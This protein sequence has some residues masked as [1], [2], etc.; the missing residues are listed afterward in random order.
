VP[1]P[2]YSCAPTARI[3][4]I[5]STQLSPPIEVVE[6]CARSF[7]NFKYRRQI[8]LRYPVRRS[9]TAALDDE[10]VRGLRFDI[11]IPVPLASDSAARTRV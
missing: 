10:R 11:I 3:G 9:L 4:P 6:L 5:T 2:V 1:S 7:T 8:H